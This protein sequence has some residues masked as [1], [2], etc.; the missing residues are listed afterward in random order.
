MA[1]SHPKLTA[2]VAIGR[3]PIRHQ[4]RRSIALLPQ[5][6]A[7]EPQGCGLIPARL[8][9][10]VQHL[11]L[12]IDGSPQPQPFA[13]NHNS[14]LVEVPLRAWPGTEPTEVAGESWPELENPAPNRLIGHV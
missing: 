6:L 8:H 7:H 13:P 11:A 2:S 14:H 9:E 3:Q 4:D 12:A 5:Q 10:H 1:G